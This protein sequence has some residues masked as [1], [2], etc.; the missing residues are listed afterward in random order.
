MG[1]LEHGANL[2]T[3]NHMGCWPSCQLCRSVWAESC[4]NSCFKFLDWIIQLFEGIHLALH[5]SDL[6]CSKL[7]L[8]AKLLFIVGVYYRL[9]NNV[10]NRACGLQAKTNCGSDPRH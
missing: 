9:V 1:P 4:C 7:L 6:G 10:C 5:R 8:D 2:H 3:P